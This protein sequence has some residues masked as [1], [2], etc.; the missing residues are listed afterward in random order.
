MTGPWYSLSHYCNKLERRGKSLTKFWISRNAYEKRLLRFFLRCS[1]LKIQPSPTQESNIQQSQ[2]VSF[3]RS[4]D[5]SNEPWEGVAKLPRKWFELR[6]LYGK[7]WIGYFSPSL[8]NTNG[9]LVNSNK[10]LTK[11][12]YLHW[13]QLAEH[14]LRFVL[15]WDIPAT[16]GCKTWWEVWRLVFWQKKQFGRKMEGRRYQ[17]GYVFFYYL[18][19]TAFQ[20][21]PWHNYFNRSLGAS[22]WR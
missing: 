22:L 8:K 21:S 11:W 13:L 7:N 14:E 3:Q 10:S 16:F 18:R 9:G 2:T 12:S 6:C 15:L 5:V 4:R 17:L 20:M 19:R 1:P